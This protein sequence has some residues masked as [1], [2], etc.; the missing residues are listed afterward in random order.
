MNIVLIY[1]LCLVSIL[2]IPEVGI[3][4]RIYSKKRFTA[5]E[6]IGLKKEINGHDLLMVLSKQNQLRNLKITKLNAKSTNYY[7]SKYNVI[8]LS[9]ITYHSYELS[10]I[11]IASHCYRRAKF[12]QH[13]TFFYLAYT[14]LHTLAKLISLIFLPSLICCAILNAMTNKTFPAL[15]LTIVLIA[16]VASF[17]IELILYLIKLGRTKSIVKDLGRSTLFETSE[18]EIVSK[19]LKCICNL[20]FFDFT[21]QTFFI[22]KIFNPDLLFNTNKKTS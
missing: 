1:V 12:A 4:F 16:Y 15:I 19:Q 11:S 20:E 13:H 8:K 9:P 14:C 5:D 3:I 18:L 17:V 22:F 2:L 10:Q 7:S 6:G 21:N